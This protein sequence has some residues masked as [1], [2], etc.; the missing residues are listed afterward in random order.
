MFAVLLLLNV[1]SSWRFL[2]HDCP[3]DLAGDEAQYWDWSRHL[4]W[5]YYSKGPLV[6]LII[7]AGTAVV[8]DTMPGVRSPVIVFTAGTSFC[9]YWLTRKLF[10]SDRLALGAFLLG[11][12]V[13]MYAAGSVLMT[14]DPPLFFCFA[15]ATCLLV[16]AA[17]DDRGWAW[18]AAGIFAGIGVMA[19]YGMLLWPPI[20]L[21]W[22]A[23]DPACRRHLRSWGPWVMTGI[24][25]GFLVPPVVWN[26]HHDW[27][28]FHHVAT[29]TT[30]EHS[31]WSW[32]SNPPLF[33]LSQAGAVNPA[34]AGVMTF[35]AAAAFRNSTRRSALL[36]STGVSPVPD[37]ARHGPDARAAKNPC[38]FLAMI[39]GSWFLICL[40]DSLVTKV[41][42]NWPAPAYFTLLILTA[43]EL[44]VRP[45]KWRPWLIGAIVF[46]L[47]TCPLLRDLRRLYP[48]AVWLDRH[49]P[50]KPAADGQS[51]SWANNFDLE[52]KMRGIR[53]PFATTISDE[54]KPLG[55]GAFVLCEDY[56]DA[57]QLAFYL[58]GQPDTF[59]AGS[60]WTDPAV[61]RRWTQFD[62][63]TDRQLDRPELIGRNVVYVGTMA[64]A[65]LRQSFAAVRR[66]P[67]IT[68]RVDGIAVRSW[69]VWECRGFK[70][71]SRPPGE[72]AR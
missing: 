66:L 70:G 56:M 71:M 47:I 34:L 58:P 53:D 57:S 4:D 25:L 9:T 52:Y 14:I 35:A 28:S 21:T 59:F 31:R 64:Y 23:V 19:K 2:T 17:F 54:L 18:V 16:K 12:I 60:Y 69:T 38:L 20:V 61:R 32:L 55:P 43:H 27:V 36:R 39:G 50:H 49:H 40:L 72:G 5:S 3:I 51:R 62:L 46:G 48:L 30:G 45:K 67:D 42:V 22:L 10:G 13:P 6:A 15:A 29:Q 41:Q 24:A 7:R 1:W 26:A 65:P 37:G 33:V 44:S 68:V 63:W 11:A 8:G